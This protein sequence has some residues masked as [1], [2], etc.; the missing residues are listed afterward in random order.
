MVWL[1]R[2]L[3]KFSTLHNCTDALVYKSHLE[4]RKHVSHQFNNKKLV[5]YVLIQLLSIW[6]SM[7][8]VIWNMLSHRQ[9]YHILT[10][11]TVT[12]CRQNSSW[13]K[14]V[15][16][17]M[18][19]WMKKSNFPIDFWPLVVLQAHTQMQ[20]LV[21]KLLFWLIGEHLQIRI[22][23]VFSLVLVAS[24]IHLFFIG[25]I[26]SIKITSLCSFFPTSFIRYLP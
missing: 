15:S 19:I 20:I 12:S 13:I 22:I 6:F 10:I 26:K 24:G 18:F 4:S 7:F 21:D 5:T 11:E 25:E 14:W 3:C 1:I 23:F 17:F 16:M 9:Q 2:I 8:I